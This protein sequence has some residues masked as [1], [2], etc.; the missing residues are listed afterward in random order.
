[1]NARRW[2]PEEL[3]ALRRLY[4]RAARAA[5]EG[6]I[7]RP[8][9]SIV[10][11]ANLLGVAREGIRW[12]RAEDVLLRSLW[13]DCARR[14]L[15]ERLGRSWHA[16]E[17]RALRLKLGRRWG[18]YM[19]LAEA[20]ACAG[21]DYRSLLPILTAYLKHWQALPSAVRE[22]LPTPTIVRSGKAFTRYKHRKIDAQAAVNAVEWWLSLES[23]VD[24]A[25]RLG[26]PLTTFRSI[27][28]RAGEVI[29]P[30]GRRE[31][32]WWDALFARRTEIDQR[33]AA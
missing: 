28:S 7:A 6:A 29:E 17:L 31:A 20:A 10:H 26:L 11:K 21:Y 14:T 5:I 13:A 24:A 19:S 23:L 9:H 2:T 32:A 30:R 12:T 4:P 1:M 33:R 27:V 8:W 16:I 25:R 3:N 18:G 22:S 15:Q